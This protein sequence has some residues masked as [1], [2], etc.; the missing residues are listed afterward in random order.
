MNI[1]LVVSG[2]AGETWLD[3]YEE[4]PIKLTFNIE[5]VLTATPKAEFSRQFRVPASDVNYEFFSTAF[6]ISGVDFNP[7]LKVP[8]RIVLD[9]SDF[10]Q[11]ELRLQNVYRNDT[12]GKIDY[13]CLFLGSAKSFSSVLGEKH[14]GELDWTDYNF[15]FDVAAITSSWQAYPESNDVNALNNGDVLFPIV[16]FGNTYNGTVTEQTR[17]ALDHPSADGGS[18]EK[19][20]HPMNVTRFKPMVRVREVVRRIFEQSGFSVTGQFF[21]T[22]GDVRQMFLSAWGNDDSVNVNNSTSNLAKWG[23]GTLA[24]DTTPGYFNIPNLPVVSFDYGSNLFIGTG[25]GGPPNFYTAY[26]IPTNGA[27]EYDLVLKLSFAANEGDTYVYVLTH[28]PPGLGFNINYRFTIS[29]G[30]GPCAGGDSLSI[31]KDTG[32]GYVLIDQICSYE[33]PSN[34]N[35]DD[36]NLGS[37]FFYE[38]TIAETISLPTAVAGTTIIPLYW[39]VTPG[40]NTGGIVTLQNDSY[41]EV[42][43]A[44]GD[45]NLSTSFNTKHKCIDFIKDLFK[46][47]RLVMIPDLATNTFEIIP[48]QQYIGSGEVKDWSG[49]LDINKDLVIRPLL[50]DQKDR[51]VLAMEDDED[52]YNNNNQTVFDESFGTRRLDSVYDIL[53]GE[54]EVKTNV[55]PTPAQQIEGYE[56]DVNWEDFTIPQIHALDSDGAETKHEPIKPKPRI[57][58]YNGLKNINASRWYLEDI[59]L[60]PPE[61]KS[62]V[63]VVSFSNQMPQGGPNNRN[64]LFE[65]ETNWAGAP[66]PYHPITGQDLYG[67]YWSKYYSLIYGKDTRRVTAY[68]VLDTTDILNFKYNDVIYVEGI[69]Y[70]VEKIYDAPLG[71]KANVKVDLITLKDYRPKVTPIP[72]TAGIIWENANVNWEVGYPLTWDMV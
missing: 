19:S 53:E 7:G 27:Y 70:Y 67:L 49:K 35:P 42:T 60:N 46:M 66:S 71:K 34:P 56:S 55:A 23:P 39:S 31:E 48:W 64:L 21:N 5:D 17:I 68:F 61:A 22:N 9:G 44:V 18:F 47:F 28:T 20:N 33:V 63:P 57:L 45:F 1:Q 72:P 3:L 8:A 29:S 58:Y 32:G 50:L 41:I 6:E 15:L 36:P 11:G 12:S 38:Y 14:I 65:R 52:V 37:T 24:L 54:T 51:V 13:E 4:E 59:N 40:T 10:K 16:D 30:T 62:N 43:E 69:Y 25:F 2:S 26:E